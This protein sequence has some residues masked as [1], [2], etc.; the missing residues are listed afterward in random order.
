MCQAFDEAWGNIAHHYSSD[1]DIERARLALAEAMLAV[2]WRHGHDVDALKN[3]ALQ[4]MALS[5]RA[6]S[7][8]APKISN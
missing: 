4:Q 6:R 8:Q 3:A 2:A 5:Y 7:D 1:N